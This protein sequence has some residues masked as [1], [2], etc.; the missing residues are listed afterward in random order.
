[1]IAQYPK[2]IVRLV[3]SRCDRKGQYRKETLIAQYGPDVTMPDLRH[4]IAKS[5]IGARGRVRATLIRYQF[6][7]SI[8]CALKA[9]R[10]ISCGVNAPTSI[11]YESYHFRVV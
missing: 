1:M 10:T 7:Q 11:R 6:S 4:L 5:A 2:A 9:G 8:K 3:C